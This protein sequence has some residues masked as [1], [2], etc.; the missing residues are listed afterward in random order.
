MRF[1]LDDDALEVSAAVASFLTKECPP[2]LV[3]AAFNAGGQGPA[4]DLARSLGEMGVLGM[5]APAGAGG[6]GLSM[7]A[8]AAVLAEAGRAAAPLP[9]T[10]TIA[11]AVPLLA[12]AGDPTGILERVALDDERVA[13]A[14]CGV[15]PGASRAGWFLVGP[16]PVLYRRDEVTLERLDSVDRTRDLATVT[17]AGPGIVLE[18]RGPGMV[19]RGAAAAAATLLGL[20]RGMLDQ[21]VAYVKDR[22]QFGRPIGSFQAVK[23]RLAD[24]LLLLELAA[25]PVW[26]AAHAL[27]TA[28]PDLPRAASLA[29]AMASDAATATAR[30]AL[31]AHGAM[32]YTDQHPL[33]LW[34]KRTWC[35][36]ASHGTAR[37][38]RDRI[39]AALQL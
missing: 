35:L 19:E 21:T 10:E 29:K 3:Q 9:L 2:E 20:G 37:W 30:A 11:L 31:Q 27:D 17:P 24:A 13:V 39:A 32:G 8:A 34:L 38:H 22:Q 36:A 15:A 25:P 28:S 18:G 33:H 14:P 5:L 26:A 16:D 6:A 1:A 23:H 7:V 12:S 4:D